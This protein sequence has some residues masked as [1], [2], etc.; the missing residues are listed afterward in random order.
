MGLSIHD[1]S[2]A[3]HKSRGVE[4]KGGNQVTYRPS[5]YSTTLMTNKFYIMFERSFWESATP[6]PGQ[7]GSNSLETELLQCLGS[8]ASGHKEGHPAVS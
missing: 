2:T 3:T 5:Y 6:R 4:F 1:G 7:E 8:I